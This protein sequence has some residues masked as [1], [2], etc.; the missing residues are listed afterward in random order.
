MSAPSRPSPSSGLTL[1]AHPLIGFD[2]E[3]TSADPWD[4]RIVTASI[5]PE[6]HVGTTW[7]ADPGVPIPDGAAAVH[8]ITTAHAQSHGR[9][10]RDVVAEVAQS[11]NAQWQSGSAIVI[12][13]A[14]YDLRVLTEEMRRHDLGPLSIGPVLDPL[15]LWRHAEKYRKGK[16]TLGDAV[17]RFGVE[18][19]TAHESAADAQAAVGVLRGLDSLV[20]WATWTPPIALEQQR[21]W[22][23]AW[24]SGLADWIRRQGGDWESVDGAWPLA[25][26]ARRAEKFD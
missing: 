10:A 11:L 17:T 15:V 13:N 1:G 26:P 9:S 24:A 12:Y 5:E 25:G 7:L 14:P 18:M 22:N 2:L 4:A 20:S 8:G 3:T 19:G 16:K 21:Q 23:E 6:G